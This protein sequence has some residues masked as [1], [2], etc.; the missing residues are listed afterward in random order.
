MKKHYI[1]SI[2]LLVLFLIITFDIYQIYATELNYE[3]LYEQHMELNNKIKVYNFK[4]ITLLVQ[5]TEKQN[6]IKLK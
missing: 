1:Y 3:E 2:I 4:I 6:K 5:Q